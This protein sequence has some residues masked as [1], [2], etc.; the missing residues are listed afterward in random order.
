MLKFPSITCGE[1]KIS[2]ISLSLPIY[3]ELIGTTIMGF[4]QGAFSAHF[5]N[6]FFVIPINLGTTAS[7][8]FVVILTLVS[9]GLSILLSA[10]LGRNKDPS[11]LIGSAFFLMIL[12]S[13]FFGTVFY[14]LDKPII[15]LMANG[16]EEYAEY[17]PY[18]M[19][20]YRYRIITFMLL[21]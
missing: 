3:F 13:L 1:K 20:Y 8:L 4:V 9:T 11:E 19:A 10:E 16:N 14:F 7:S 2:L 6:G 17:L 5:Q 18:A 21:Q 12:I 15:S